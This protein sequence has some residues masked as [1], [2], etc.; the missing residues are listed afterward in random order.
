MSNGIFQNKR[1][2][3]INLFMVNLFSN[4]ARN[5]C[6]ANGAQKT[7]DLHQE[8]MCLPRVPPMKTV[9]FLSPFWSDN[10]YRFCSCWNKIGYGFQG[11]SR[12]PREGDTY[13]S[14]V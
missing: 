1:P 11:S 2:V 8:G 5:H 13:L 12:E 14:L 10:G 7:H 6:E 3:R 4:N 9:E